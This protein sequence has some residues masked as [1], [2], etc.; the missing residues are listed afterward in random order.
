MCETTRV[1]SKRT[2]ILGQMKK[3]NVFSFVG[4]NKENETLTEKEPKTTIIFSLLSFR[5]TMLSCLCTLALSLFMRVFFSSP[6][7]HHYLCSFHT[8]LRSKG[9]IIDSFHHIRQWAT[10]AVT[11]PQYLPTAIQPPPSESTCMCFWFFLTH[12]YTRHS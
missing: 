4:A 1:G 3:L 9:Q 8:W 6:S 5:S 12:H 10:K 7:L 11:H 2:L